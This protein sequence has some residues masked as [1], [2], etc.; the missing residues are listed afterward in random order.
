MCLD[1]KAKKFEFWRAVWGETPIA[2]LPIF[3]TLSLFLISTHSENLIHVAVTVE[4]F[5]TLED[6]IEKDP[7]NLGPPI[8]VAQKSSL[9]SSI[10]QTL[11]TVRLAV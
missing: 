7:L 9:I 2:A 5:K 10:A 4:K 1:L 11:N 6:P 3:A 8:S